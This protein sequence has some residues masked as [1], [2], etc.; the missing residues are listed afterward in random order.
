MALIDT[1]S[2]TAGKANVDAF[3]NLN[4]ALSNTTASVGKVRAMSEN[5]DGTVTGAA[6]LYSP[7]TAED[8][9]LRAGIDQQAFALSFEGTNIARDRLQQND[10]TATSA[11]AGGFLTVNSG[12]SVTTGQGSN[13]RTYRT[14][15]LFGQSPTY[16]EFWLKE[17]NQT[18]TSA[19]TE[20]GAGYCSGVT[21]QL[22]DGI[23]L[24]RLSGGQLRLVVCNNSSDVATADITETNIPPMDGTGSFSAAEVNRYTIVAYQDLVRCFI[25]SSL[26]ATLKLNSAASGPCSSSAQPLF[27]RVYNSGAASAARSIGIAYASVSYGNQ[28]AGRPWSHA[29]CGNGGGSYQ[30]QPGTAS[31]P[32]VSRGASTLG[33]PTSGTASTTG[34]WTATSAPALNSL[35]GMFTSPA[36]STLTTDADYPVFSYQNPA[37]TATLPGKTLYITGCRVSEQMARAAASTNV[38]FLHMALGVGGTTSATTASEAATVVAARLIPIGSTFWPSTAAVGDTKGGWVLDFSAAPLAVYPGHFLTFIVRPSGTVASNTLTIF[39]MVSFT[40]YHE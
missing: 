26:V 20:F 38:I 33:W 15:P 28:M 34:T 7:E 16:Y 36:I 10:T 27:A 8:Y 12:A 32:T 21:A 11:Q 31:G 22:T 37:G 24:R 6:F 4:V 23:F 35:G 9:C 30:I 3:Y 14:F 25:N 13:I 1:G 17:T 39:G 29:L 18:A 19:V 2:S 40:G 5:D